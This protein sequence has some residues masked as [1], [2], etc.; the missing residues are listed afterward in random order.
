M[1]ENIGHHLVEF[2]RAMDDLQDIKTRAYSQRI[3]GWAF[4]NCELPSHGKDPTKNWEGNVGII[5]LFSNHR[6]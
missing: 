6:I 2:C 4:T 5:I 3:T 1:V